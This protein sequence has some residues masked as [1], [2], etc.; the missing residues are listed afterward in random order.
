MAKRGVEDL[1]DGNQAYLKRQK[2]SNTNV[3]KTTSPPTEIRSARELRRLLSFDQDSTRSKHGKNG[4][5]LGDICSD[6]I[7][8]IESFKAFL[9]PFAVREN[10]HTHRIAILREFFETSQSREEEDKPVTYLPDLMQTW[11]FAAQSNDELLLS[12]IPA[13]LAVLLRTLSSIL[14]LVQHGL[15]VCRTIL[16]KSQLDLISRGLMVTKGKTF[17]LSPILRLLNQLAMFDGGE[18]AKQVFRARDY[19]LKGLARNL[20]L[21]ISGE[22]AEDRKKPSVRTNALRF[23]LSLLKFLPSE[24]KREL[25]YQRDIV[26]A[27]TKDIK[28]DPPF[29]ICEALE[30]LKTSVLQDEKLPR[31]AKA[32]LL[33]AT[34]LGRIAMLYGYDQPDEELTKAKKTVEGVAHEFLVLACMS[35]ELGALNRQAGFYPRGIDP[36]DL[37]DFDDDKALLDL[38]LHSVEW[39]DKFTEKVPI[40]NTILSDFIQTLRP[41]SNA[42]QRDLILSIFR[43]APELVA[44]YFFH[45]K[46]FSFEPKLT[47]TWIGY[48]AFLFS[49][50][51]LPLPI[52]FGHQQRY[53]RLPPPP[54]I[55]LESILPQPLSQKVL[56]GC[57][58]QPQKLITF[59]AIRILCVAFRK[60]QIA[61]RMYE[62][63][64]SGSSSLWAQA[65]ASLTDAFCK[66]CPSIKDVIHAF[67]NMSD[68]DLLQRESATRLLVLYYEIVPSI[69]LDAK[70][71]VSGV[72]TQRL[73]EIEGS[74]LSPEDRSLCAMELENLFQFAHFSP[75][76]RWFSKAEGVHVSPFTAMLKLSAEAPVD[77]PLLKLKLVLTSISEENQVLQTQTSIS[78]LE[79]FILVLRSL[80][81]IADAHQ[82]YEFLDDCISRCAA[83]PIKYIFGLEEISSRVHDAGHK[84]SPFSLLTLVIA[85]QWPFLIKS[86]SDAALQEVARFV[87]SYLAT[88]LKIKEDKKII[89]DVIQRLAAAIPEHSAARSTIEGTRNLVDIITVPERKSKQI[90]ETE[91]KSN[92]SNV[93]FESDDVALIANMLEDT[94]TRAADSSSLVKWVNKDV[95]EV[96]EGGH[97]AA[98]VMLLSSELLSV[99]KEAVTNI[100]KFAAKLKD[101]AFEEKDQVWLLLSEVVETAKKCTDQEPLPTVISAFASHAIPVLSDPLHRLYPKINN[102]LSQGPMWE[103]D[104]IPLMYKILDEPPSFDDAYYQETNWLLTYL[105]A[106]LRS[107][108]DMAIYRKRRA[109]EKLLSIWNNAYL[110]P[111]VRDKILRLLFR[112]TTIEGGSTTLITRFSAMTWI[113]AQVALGTGMS[114]KALME[115]ILESSDKQRVRKWSKG[116]NVGVVKADIMKF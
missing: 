79:S 95:E 111:G 50:L 106:G 69:A 102:F 51:Q 48:S 22:E 68:T 31:D 19:T 28:D 86:A 115:R 39:M 14:D 93:P 26:T 29:L 11:S 73:R 104:K 103:A 4:M 45:K 57:L 36:D 2:I 43:S 23:L 83:K 85:E 9:D 47:A 109:F 90:E 110:A 10:D 78:A 113:E 17:I 72:L 15:G 66:R 40:R 5:N 64:A 56:R 34:S 70:F 42:K 101:S 49:S 88:L 112:A 62:D 52:Y 82:V 46:S 37:E 75:G 21:R 1:E 30:N 3:S 100:S 32:K 92:K 24:S 41:W 96:I 91:Q 89:K 71:D 87:A 108:A 12:A 94:D 63:A 81:G 65:T 58:L 33:N 98:L 25:L 54:T 107:P 80:R 116:V 84:L 16:Q 27:M 20:H 99:R 59:F 77:V 67:R 18:M 8:A 76:M 61:L 7:P 44:D 38:G 105:L 6:T 60:F 13:V 53:A 35:P 97:A 55:V 74:N 114:L